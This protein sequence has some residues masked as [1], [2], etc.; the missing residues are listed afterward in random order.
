LP[1][2]GDGRK[3]CIGGTR[4]DK[5]KLKYWCYSVQEKCHLDCPEIEQKLLQYR[6]VY[7]PAL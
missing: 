6:D 5:D 4:T 1:S 2:G 7:P 3:L